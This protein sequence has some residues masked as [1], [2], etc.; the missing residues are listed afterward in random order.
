MKAEIKYK[1]DFEEL[2]DKNIKSLKILELVRRKGIISRTEISKTTDIN[3]V[4]ISNYIKKYIDN[5]LIMEKGFDVSTGGRK[6]ELVELDN[7]DNRVIGV[8]IAEERI[9]VTLADIGLNV[10]GR[11][12]GPRSVGVKDAVR[13]TCGLIEEVIRKAGLASGALKCIGV[14]TG[15]EDHKALGEEIEGRFKVATFV[16]DEPS[17]AAF[18]EKGKNKDIPAGDM[19]YIYSDIGYGIIIKEDGN[20]VSPESS[21]YLRPWDEALGSVRLAKRD[22]AKGVGT[23][24]VEV[25]KGRMENITEAAIVE[26]AI[27]RDEVALSIMRSVGVSLGLRIAYLIN[28]FGP[29]CIVLGGG[30]EKAERLIIEPIKSTVKKLALKDRSNTPI[31]PGALGDDAVSMGAAALA[32]REIFLKI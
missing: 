24:I 22:V 15:I 4:S 11:A 3:M 18:G 29:R 30:I 16:G 21:K 2:S 7:N 31:I 9:C 20:R 12:E 28:I 13:E 23:T 10:I 8:D 1:F 5:K 27:G 25:A 32:A 14:G 6:P 26:A 19:L 17:C